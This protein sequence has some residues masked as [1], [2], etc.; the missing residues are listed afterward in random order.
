MAI[1]G[2][3]ILGDAKYPSG[4]EWPEGLDQKLYLHARRISFPHP[5]G[6]GV[7]DVTA[8]LPPHM[9]KA[10]AAFGFEAKGGDAESAG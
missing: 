6:E 10:F 7:V 2:H 9:A 1:I 5:S 4:A 3:P 8:P